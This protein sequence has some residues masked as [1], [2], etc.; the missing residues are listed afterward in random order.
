MEIDCGDCVHEYDVADE[1]FVCSVNKYPDGYCTCDMGHPPC[2]W[3]TDMKFEE[4]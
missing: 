3:C 4:R 1:C 2:A